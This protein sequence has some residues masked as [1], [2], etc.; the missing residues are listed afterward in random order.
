MK[1]LVYLATVALLALALIPS[2]SRANLRA[3]SSVTLSTVRVG[4]KEYGSSNITRSTRRFSGS[5]SSRF[6]KR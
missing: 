2:A 5:G 4:L 1:R 6:V 3:A